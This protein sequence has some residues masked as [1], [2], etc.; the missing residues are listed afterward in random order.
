MPKEVRY[1]AGSSAELLSAVSGLLNQ[2]NGVAGLDSNGKLPNSRLNTNV[3]I[4]DSTGKL[5]ETMFPGNFVT[6]DSTGKLS[7]AFLPSNVVMLDAQGKLPL[8]AIPTEIA[9]GVSAGA[10]AVV[11][12]V[13]S[14]ASGTWVL[15]SG[16]S[17]NKEYSDSSIRITHNL[18]KNPLAWTVLNKE[19]TPHVELPKSSTVNL[20]ADVN[21]NYVIITNVGSLEKFSITLTF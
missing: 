10:S 8:T 1:G 4:M 15:P 16:V 17:V 5:P 6:T 20:Q 9:E 18:G 19:N 21:A 11:I 2:A 3:A 7:S 12:D 14:W 13:T